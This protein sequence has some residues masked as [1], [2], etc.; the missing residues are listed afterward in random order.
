[1]KPVYFAILTAK[2][3]EK[4]AQATA[5]QTTLKLTE[6]AVGDANGQDSQPSRTQTQLINECRRAPINALFVDSL[7][8]YQLIAEQIIPEDEG[9]WW[10][11][12]IGLFDEDGELCAVANCPPT[13]K[14]KLA[15]GSG[16]TQIIRLVLTVTS[17]DVVEIKTNPDIALATRQYVEQAISRAVPPGTLRFFARPAAPDGY[18]VCHG[19]AVSRHTYAALFEAIGVCFGEGDGETTFNLP[20]CRGEFIRGWDNGRGVDTGRV[21]GSAQ[22]HAIQSHTHTAMSE[23]AGNHHHGGTTSID[24]EHTHLLDARFG[25]GGEASQS[26]LCNYSGKDAHAL[27]SGNHQHTIK[28]DGAHQHAINI[29]TTGGHETRPSNIA[30]LICIKY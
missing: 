16:R 17:T 1:M 29:E 15:E 18:L 5:N 22:S 24:G 14:P 27:P 28:E 13:Y 21:F 19:E 20:D 10:I 6:M 26:H 4:L 7:N 8:P 30:M 9:G 3:E 12:E 25:G 23:E 2:G 11:R